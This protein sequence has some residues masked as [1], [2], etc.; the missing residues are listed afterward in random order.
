MRSIPAQ[1]RY[2]KSQIRGI[3]RNAA[4]LIGYD[5]QTTAR[6]ET[7][8]RV[9]LRANAEAKRP[10]DWSESD[11]AIRVACSVCALTIICLGLVVLLGWVLHSEH[12]MTVLPGR[13]R[14]KSNA[15]LGFIACG[16]ALLLVLRPA[17]WLRRLGRM[18]SVMAMA[19]GAAALAEYLFRVDL[20]IDQLFF[21]DNVQLQFPGRMAQI[22]AANFCL[23][24]LSILLAAGGRTARA[25]AQ[26][27]AV[28]VT[29]SAF[30]AI[31]GFLYGVPLLYGSIGY[32][33]MALH[34]GAGFLV[35]GAALLMARPDADL[36][37]ILSAPE[38]GGWMARRVLP[39][40]LAVPVVLGF[41][42]LLP[43]VSFGGPRFSMALFAVTVSGAGVACLLV[44]ARFLNREERQR[45]EMIR[46]R[47]ESAA[48]VRRS[49]QELQLITDHLPTLISYISP[50]GRFLRV[51][52][53]YE[54]WTGMPAEAIVGQTI[55]ELLGA[56]Y[57]AAT[58]EPRQRAMGGETVT[59]EA[60]YPV[61]LGVRYAQV[62]YAPDIDE[63]GS[64]RGIA[65]MVLDVEERRQIELAR[66]ESE[67]L[68]IANL[69]LHELSLT[70]PLTGLRNRRAFEERLRTD[71]AFCV[72]HQ[73]SLSALMMDI[74]N[75]KLLNDTWGHAAG[76]DVLRR[77][78][79][80]LLATVRVPDVAVRYG[81]EE[82]AVL[83]PGSNLV[84][85]TVVAERIRCRIGEHLWPNGPLT[86]SIGVAM[87]TLAMSVP[88]QLMESADAALYLAKR[89]GKDRV[90][91][92]GVT[93]PVG[94]LQTP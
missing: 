15:A 3:W 28:L 25:A 69:H 63:T 54:L 80:I 16:T 7:N 85:A 21:R 61:K 32:T 77:L 31:V 42:Y 60:L 2:H 75:F 19:W 8:E 9:S 55:E 88:A 57:W 72:R 67:R 59:F 26:W 18:L 1:V 13:I 14:M 20:H 53:T 24:G 82:F 73:S 56:E 71:F 40:V 89:S 45:A 27:A 5:L 94:R 66:L 92:A 91:F 83:L 10:E 17:A 46:V 30:A 29:G 47:E 22:T 23:S 49:E 87:R 6:T 39:G 68:E 93:G 79:R 50:E 12:L 33:S 34:T 51:N 90:C 41:L 52:R 74:D 78:G 64:M 58:A 81:G 35:L 84:Q 86:L 44:L 11:S 43:A 37:R 70:D 48:A 62:T 4:I 36:M 76:D 65:C 38:A